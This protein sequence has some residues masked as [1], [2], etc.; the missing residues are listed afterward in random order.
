M[1][2]PPARVSAADQ[3]TSSAAE[4]TVGSAAHRLIRRFPWQFGPQARCQGSAPVKGG[5]P[6]GP[7]TR[8]SLV[9]GALLSGGLGFSAG[10]AAQAG[11]GGVTITSYGHSAIVV[12][13]GGATVLLNP[14]QAVGC[15]AGLAEPRMGAD[16][17]LASSRLKDEGASVASGRLLVKP[18]SYRVAGLKIEGIAAPHDRV[19][20]KRFGLSPLWRW[21]QGGLE[22]AHLGGTTATLKPEDRVLLGRP[23]VLII[24]VGGGAKVYTG[25]EAAAVV[26]EL[27]PRRVIPVQYRNAAPSASCDVGSVEPFLQAMSPA[28]V[29]RSGSSVSLIPPLGEGPVIE[30]LR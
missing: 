28:K 29:M 10:P 4:Q 22:F 20:G 15:A 2:T 25:Q 30:V 17:I 16:V 7:I 21:S 26:R 27:Q 9:C 12:R 3:K 23:D 8:G 5:S 6:K 13:G 18:G 11:G 19:G 24:G 14:F 1:A